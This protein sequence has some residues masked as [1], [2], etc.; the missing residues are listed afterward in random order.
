LKQERSGFLIKEDFDK[1]LPLLE[2]AG[3]KVD[4]VHENFSRL[5]SKKGYFMD[6][7]FMFVDD[8]VVNQIVNGGKEIT[9][10]GEKFIVPSLKHLIALKLHSIKNNPQKR[11]FIDLPDIIQLIR[12]NKVDCRDK[13]F[14]ELC[15]KYGTEEIYRKIL[16]NA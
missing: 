8:G 5:I 7:D 16:E 9:I 3:C 6:V 14:R 4:Y 11:Q 13:D 12:I 15:L 2:E 10:A 1:I